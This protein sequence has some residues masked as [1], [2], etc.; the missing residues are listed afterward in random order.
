MRDDPH[1][2]EDIKPGS[3]MQIGPDEAHGSRLQFLIVT[4][5][6]SWGVRGDLP[7]GGNVGRP[8]SLVEPTGGMVVFDKDGKRFEPPPPT[9]KH[10]A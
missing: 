4:K 6:E 5:V 1:L 2:I 3:I 7:N 10:H 9:V 8:W